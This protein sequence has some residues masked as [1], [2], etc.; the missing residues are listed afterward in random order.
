MNTSDRPITARWLALG[1]L[2]LA[3]LALFQACKRPATT[4]PDLKP[5]HAELAALRAAVQRLETASSVPA[6]APT[7]AQTASSD[8]VTVRQ[9]HEWV[10]KLEQRLMELEQGVTQLRS[11]PGPTPA[12]APDLVQARQTALNPQA[13][14]ADRL[15]ALRALRGGNGRT[16][17]VVQ[18]MLQL[19]GSTQD[20]A[21]RADI[22]RNLS[23]VKDPAMK[24]AL[25]DGM[26]KDTDPKV[27]EEAAETLAPFWA[28]PYV[29]A[30]L[31]TAAHHDASEKVRA[32]AREVLEK[33]GER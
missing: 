21:I 33:K 17:E 27:R 19:F 5:L 8:E 20:P 10:W 30:S 15:A 16:P 6:T 12:P 9:V 32:Q 31:K 29:Q 28:D 3:I 23:G 25:I 18:A 24:P 14:P 13:S 7:A 22:F 26:L 11:A 1:A 2:A 4:P